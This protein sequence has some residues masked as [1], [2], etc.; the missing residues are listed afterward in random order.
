MHHIMLS[1]NHSRDAYC[2]ICF[3]AVT[4]NWLLLDERFGGVGLG[5]DV[6]NE[7]C[8]AARLGSMLSSYVGGWIECN[9]IR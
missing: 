3:C 2:N 4:Q 1:S 8:F 9:L 6:M 7:R 5:G